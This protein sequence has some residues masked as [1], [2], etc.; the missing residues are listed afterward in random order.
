LKGIQA[1]VAREYADTEYRDRVASIRMQ[2]YGDS[3]VKEDVRKSL[4]ALGGAAGVLWLVACVN[5]TSVLLAC[6]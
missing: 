2:R 6:R 1:G 3:L 4:M 5:V